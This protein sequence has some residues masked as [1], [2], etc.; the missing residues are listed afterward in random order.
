MDSFVGRLDVFLLGVLLAFAIRRSGTVFT[1][2]W[3]LAAGCTFILAA[4]WMT[5]VQD[6]ERLPF[7]YPLHMFLLVIGWIMATGYLVHRETV[8]TRLLQSPL[9]QIPGIMCYSIYIWH[10]ML[11][12]ILNPLDGLHTVIS[13]IVATFGLSLLTYLTLERGSWN[14]LQKASKSGLTETF[15]RGG[16]TTG[17]Q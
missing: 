3:V 16:V 8:A 15:I 6:L 1:K 14:T 13:I 12:G 4:F 10:G 5:D 7:L 2:G 9:L 17:S 11:L